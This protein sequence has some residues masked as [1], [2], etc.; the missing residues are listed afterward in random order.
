M[1]AHKPK[2]GI[3]NETMVKCICSNPECEKTFEKTLSHYNQTKKKGGNQY[4]SL[5]C[6]GRHRAISNS[7]HIPKKKND[8]ELCFNY[9]IRTIKHNNNKVIKRFGIPKIETKDLD[10][11]LKNQNG[12][13]NYSGILLTP[14]LP[15]SRKNKNNDHFTS[16]SL[17]RIDSNKGY[18]LDNI[19]LIS[20][21]MNWMKNDLSDKEFKELLRLIKYK[22]N[23][24]YSFCINEKE[25]FKNMCSKFIRRIKAIEYCL[26][27]EK[28]LRTKWEE[29]NG[30]C[31]ITGVKLIYA[32][33][34][35][36][37][38]YHK[39]YIDNKLLKASLDRIDSNKGYFEGNIQFVLKNINFAKNNSNNEQFK[40]FFT[41]TFNC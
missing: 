23:D 36:Y 33:N 3:T 16:I 32:V 25:E 20:T 15:N 37:K 19:Q 18:V 27:N 34:H 11:I 6:I 39:N 29:Q 17:D 28:I 22:P 21:T 31:A 2:N 26:I 9:M 8:W 14:R 24:Y 41:S 1:S 5:Y 7:I 40:L 38:K 10:F 12:L 4:C 13:C 35:S 30:L